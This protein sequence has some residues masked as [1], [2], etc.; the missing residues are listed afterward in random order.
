MAFTRSLPSVVSFDAEGTLATH[1][2]SIAVWQEVVPS[3]YGEKHG[4]DL[5]VAKQTVYAEFMRI[6]M[7]RREWFDID[8]WFEKFGLGPAGPVIEA[9]RHLIE[10]YPEAVPV[11]ERLHPE[12]RLVVASST[13]YE[14]LEPLLRDISPYFMRMFSATSEFGAVKDAS[15]FRWMCRELDVEPSDVVH[16]GDSWKKDHLSSAEAGLV[17]F[18]LDRNDR[19]SGHLHDLNDLLVALGDGSRTS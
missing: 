7:K 18:Y 2:F 13:P 12:C 4:I 9:H 19:D 3:L 11:L 15:F 1:D 8:Y 10:F 17:S 5:Q 14:F 6:G 16:V